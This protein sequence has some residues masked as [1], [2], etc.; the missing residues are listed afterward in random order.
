MKTSEYIRL[1]ID[2]LPK[3]YV[4][5][6]SDFT[7]EVNSKEA[8]IK[9]LNRMASSGKIVKLSKGKFYKPEQT[10]F[11][12][13]EPEEKQI[14]KDL[15]EREGKTIGYL[16][17]ISIYNQLKLTTQV[18]QVIEIGR[19]SIRPSLKR[20]MYEVKFVRQKNTITKESIPL[21]QLLDVLRF[22]KK[23]P[24]TNS[25]TVCKRL[26]SLLKEL[27]AEKQQNIIRLSKKYSPSTRA[28]LGALLEEINT[29]VP[30]EDLY[31][32]LNPITK[33][34]FSFSKAV[35]PTAPN[36]NIK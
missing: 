8:I 18:N 6:Y 1:T 16:T 10:P 22:V 5:T 30:L 24:D 33:Y 34:K 15:L 27:S 21:L 9:S 35:L 4:F 3:G 7:S 31:K 25:D 28:L 32:S 11:G 29:D 12:V 20:G 2:K 23:I 26:L 36:W 19:N 13:L 14:V 17:G